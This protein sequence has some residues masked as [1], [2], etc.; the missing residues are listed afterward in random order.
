M[1]LFQVSLTHEGIMSLLLLGCTIETNLDLTTASVNMLHR[2]NQTK[3]V[4]IQANDLLVLD[5]LL[6][7]RVDSQVDV[8]AMLGVSLAHDQREGNHLRLIHVRLVEVVLF[9]VIVA[10]NACDAVGSHHYI[11]S[12]FVAEDALLNEVVAHAVHEPVPLLGR[13]ELVTSLDGVSVRLSVAVQ[14][15]DAEAVLEVHR[16]ALV[17]P[18]EAHVDFLVASGAELL[19]PLLKNFGLSVFNSLRDNDKESL[20]FGLLDNFDVVLDIDHVEVLETRVTGAGM[21]Y[22]WQLLGLEGCSSDVLVVVVQAHYR[23]VS[24]E[25]LHHRKSAWQALRGLRVRLLWSVLVRKSA[26]TGTVSHSLL[27][28]EL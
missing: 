4:E 5:K 18:R 27:L 12:F 16:E 24:L 25:A 13:A 8:P 26:K 2:A 10:V 28:V 9:Q 17:E 20:E 19:H 21:H 23:Q 6:F 14:R 3:H 1:L 15:V 7:G 11:D 22:S